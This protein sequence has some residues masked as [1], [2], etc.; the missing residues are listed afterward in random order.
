MNNC[1][2]ESL[3]DC[4]GGISREHIVSKSLFVSS[5]VD[6]KGFEWC[7]EETE[8]IG[9]ASLTKK[10][11]CRKHNSQLSKIDSAAAHAFDV[12]RRQTKLSNDR[13]KQPEKKYKK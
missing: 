1:W 6:V 11:L 8:R 4:D 2:A 10:V 9:L 13:S 3:G 7:K 12:L 5:Y